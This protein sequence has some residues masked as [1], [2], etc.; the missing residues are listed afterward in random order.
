MAKMLCN[1][2][3]AIRN[4][5]LKKKLDESLAIQKSMDLILEKQDKFEDATRC[6]TCGSK[7]DD[8]FISCRYTF[9]FQKI[10]WILF[11]RKVSYIWSQVNLKNRMK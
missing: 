1:I 7:F 10:T 2:F 6:N 11:A 5:N 8:N 3:I 9:M 4:R